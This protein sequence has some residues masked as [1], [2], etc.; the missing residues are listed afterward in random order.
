VFAIKYEAKLV[1]KMILFLNN[2]DN[3][4]HLYFLNKKFI[5]KLANFIFS[6]IFLLSVVS[7]D[8][9][10]TSTDQNSTGLVGTWQ[11]KSLT[12]DN[13]SILTEAFGTSYSTSFKTKLLSSDYK[14]VFSKD[15]NKGQASG[16][17]TVELQ[18]NINGQTITQNSKVDAP[19]GSGTWNL[20][21]STLTFSSTGQPDQVVEVTKLDANNFEYKQELL[22]VEEDSGVKT[23][24]KGTY[25]G[26]L[27]K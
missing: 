9:D 12:C 27:T 4:V 20:D 11:Y 6:I 7:C 24:T 2:N 25:Y 16:S 21:G 23:T 1:E 3:I 22:I 26:K 13:G 14:V 8:K 17:I 10:D 19:F 15:P 18:S 5:M